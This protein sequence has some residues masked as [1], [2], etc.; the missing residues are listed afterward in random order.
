MS[1]VTNVQNG[2]LT[3]QIARAEKKNALS[4]A[5]YEAMTRALEQA[6]RDDAVRAVLITGQSGVFTS[7]NDLQDFLAHPPTGQDSPVYRFM[8]AFA[9]LEKPIVAAVTG[10][11]IGI[12][13]TLLLHCDLVYVSDDA[14]LAMPFVSLG[15][16]PEF[17][18]SFLIPRLVGYVKAFDKLVLGTPFTGVE[19]VAMGLA[20]DSLASADV[21]THAR[22]VAERFN[23][24]PAEAVRESKRLL[25]AGV[26]ASVARAMS[27]EADTFIQRLQSAEAKE[28]LAAFLQKRKTGGPQSPGG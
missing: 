20:N 7:G 15:L 6:A 14:K 28:A 5:M 17:A 4:L 23:Q 1:I 9:S 13:T 16:V 11:A 26:E 12:G 3:L 18:S 2:V 19:A 25:R 22:R 21:V 24:L 10:T 8:K 27:E